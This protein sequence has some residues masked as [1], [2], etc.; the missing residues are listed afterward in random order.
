MTFCQAYG[1]DRRS[2]LVVLILTLGSFIVDTRLCI[3]DNYDA[4][5]I[6]RLLKLRKARFCL[7]YAKGTSKLSYMVY[8]LEKPSKML[9]LEEP[10]RASL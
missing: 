5:D 4:I 8:L 9:T 6:S 3:T 1:L 7:K 10:H 2:S